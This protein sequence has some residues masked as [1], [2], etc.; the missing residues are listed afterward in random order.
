MIG[1]DKVYQALHA[2][3]LAIGDGSSEEEAM[4]AAL[5]SCDLGLNFEA[6]REYCD[7]RIEAQH[8]AIRELIKLRDRIK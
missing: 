2:Y 4:R 3:N 6:V 7:K 1:E 5:E 8:E